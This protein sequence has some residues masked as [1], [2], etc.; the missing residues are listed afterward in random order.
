MRKCCGKSPSLHE[1]HKTAADGR[2][3]DIYWYECENCKRR[4][5]YGYD[6]PREAEE[7]WNDGLIG[8]VKQ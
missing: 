3:M 8:K 1:F 2:P 6:S 5:A 7:A 4:N